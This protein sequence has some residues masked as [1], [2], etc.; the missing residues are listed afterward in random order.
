MSTRD[1]PETIGDLPKIG[2]PATS[3]LM[4]EGVTT[5]AGVAAFGRKRLAGLHGVGP[6]AIRILAEELES[7]GLEVSE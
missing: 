3:A 6:K 1:L 4:V 2:R 7:R 5:L